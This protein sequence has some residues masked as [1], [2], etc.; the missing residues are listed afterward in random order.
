MFLWRGASSDIMSLQFCS[1]EENRVSMDTWFTPLSSAVFENPSDWGENPVMISVV[2]LS[3]VLCVQLPTNACWDLSHVCV[4][5]DPS[6]HKNLRGL[7]GFFKNILFSF[8]FLGCNTKED[9][10]MQVIQILSYSLVI[11]NFSAD[12][13]R[14]TL[15]IFQAVKLFL[16][17]ITLCSLYIRKILCLRVWPDR[18]LSSCYL[19][20]S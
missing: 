7:I 4:Y 13:S 15:E 5:D 9:P 2:V 6:L 8:H 1:A 18:N 12:W 14:L 19:S 17:G 11:V 16:I 10:Q 20:A 3:S